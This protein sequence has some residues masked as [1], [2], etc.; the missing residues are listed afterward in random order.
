MF[1]RPA[2]LFPMY[3]H[4]IY[5]FVGN[6]NE[7]AFGAHLLRFPKPQLPKVQM[8]NSVQ[9][10][11]YR[12]IPTESL[13]ESMNSALIS[14][15]AEEIPR[16]LLFQYGKQPKESFYATT[17]GQ[18]WATNLSQKMLPDH[19]KT[20]KPVTRITKDAVEKADMYQ[21]ENAAQFTKT[22]SIHSFAPSKNPYLRSGLVSKKAA[23]FPFRGMIKLRN[24]LVKNEEKKNS[25]KL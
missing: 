22:N 7:D 9:K 11:S 16:E 8:Y 1:E 6:W 12:P 25:R 17:Y 24:Q 14:G 2:G 19:D 21:T 3:V 15:G 4:C 23:E 5:L 13:V 20:L 18:S 10:L